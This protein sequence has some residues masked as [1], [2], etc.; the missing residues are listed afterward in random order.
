MA[1][2]LC[3]DKPKTLV[4]PKVEAKAEKYVCA[5]ALFLSLKYN[6]RQPFEAQLIEAVNDAESRRAKLSS[7]INDPRYAVVAIDAGND[8]SAFLFRCWCLAFDL[9]S[10]SACRLVS[11]VECDQA[12]RRRD[13]R[14]DRQDDAHTHAR[15]RRSRR[16][17]RRFS[18]H[19][20][21]SA[22][23]R[24]HQGQQ[25]RQTNDI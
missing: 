22:A 16:R 25:Q 24:R 11:P 17:C 19:K 1:H 12:G 15:Q 18:T 21:S 5:R 2:V 8:K 3:V 13:W 23:R 7:F 4:K 14:R 10:F 6:Y 9:S 20:A